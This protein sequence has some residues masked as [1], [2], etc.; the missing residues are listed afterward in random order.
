MLLVLF[1]DFRD[2][3]RYQMISRSHLYILV[4]LENVHCIICA[5]FAGVIL[6][7]NQ[8]CGAVLDITMITCKKG[9]V[10]RKATELLQL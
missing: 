5:K 10:R 7:I 2:T 3:K 1:N 4:I 9:K 6:P 8:M